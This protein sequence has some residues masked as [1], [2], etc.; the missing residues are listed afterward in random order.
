MGLLDLLLPGNPISPLLNANRGSLVNG[1]SSMLGS[2][3]DARGAL[4]AAGKG[5]QAGQVRDDAFAK[6]QQEQAAKAAEA[7]QAQ[8]QQ[9]AQI[10][11][12]QKNAPQYAGMVQN[13][14]MAPT[15]VGKALSATSQPQNDPAS[16][17]EYK[18]YANQEMKAGRSPQSYRDWRT[19]STQTVRAGVGQPIPMRN[20]KTGEIH[21]FQ[22]MTDGSNVDILTGQ[23]GT[24][25]DWVYDP[26]GFAGDKASAIAEGK[27]GGTVTGNLPVAA[28]AAENALQTVAALRSDKQG[29]EETFGH[30]GPF[31]I[32]PS[33]IGLTVPGTHKAD[34]GAVLGQAKGQAFLTAY[35]TLRGAGAITEA[36][37]QK[38]G[39]AIARINDPNISVEAFNIALDDYEAIIKAGYARLQ[40]QAQL[41]GSGDPST[42]PQIGDGS[43]TE[44]LV[45]KYLGQ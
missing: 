6:V 32:I 19:G 25:D 14:L 15:D 3:N 28:Q 16:I 33:Q 22:S 8:Q 10:A 5:I 27:I 4:L 21:P 24:A 30:Y 20:K 34:F 31:G 45:T 42:F 40:Q 7:T 43:T 17:A 44:D 11:W 29:Q 39:Q 18:F 38:A 26:V 35:T 41:S 2:G 13:G 12:L 1:F 36:E 9:A 37:G 23:P